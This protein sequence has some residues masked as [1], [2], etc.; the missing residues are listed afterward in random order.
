MSKLA[1]LGAFKH[2]VFVF[3]FNW[4]VGVLLR[5]PVGGERHADE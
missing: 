4:T 3:V 5:L 1:F 2:F